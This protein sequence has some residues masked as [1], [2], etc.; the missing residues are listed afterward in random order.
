[1]RRS[2]KKENQVW[3]VAMTAS[4]GP[5]DEACDRQDG[6]AQGR[7]QADTGAQHAR[8]DQGGSLHPRLCPEPN[9]S[10]LAQLVLNI[11]LRTRFKLPVQPNPNLPHSHNLSHSQQ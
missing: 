6:V 2:A 11:P 3:I 10:T 7:H 4:A 1:M 9:R 5:R 8:C